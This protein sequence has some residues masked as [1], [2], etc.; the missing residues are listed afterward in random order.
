MR[1]RSRILP[2][3]NVICEGQFDVLLLPQQLKSTAAG[4]I[5][6]MPPL[7]PHAARH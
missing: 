1:Q 3:A 6:R 2:K 4:L 5:Q 7:V